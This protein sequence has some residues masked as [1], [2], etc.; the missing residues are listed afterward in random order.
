[1]RYKRLSDI[2]PYTFKPEDAD[3]YFGPLIDNIQNFFTKKI[4]DA[5]SSK[6]S[7]INILSHY[8]VNKVTGEKFLR[9]STREWKTSYDPEVENFMNKKKKRRRQSVLE[10]LP[11][12]A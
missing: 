12:D 8:E 5:V 4:N 7:D 1:M 6:K 3:G 10:Q 9:L 2:E 11:K